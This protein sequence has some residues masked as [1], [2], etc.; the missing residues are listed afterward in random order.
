MLNIESESELYKVEQVAKRL[1]LVAPVA[2]RVNPN[3]DAKTYLFPSISTGLKKNR[4]FVLLLRMPYVFI[5][6]LQ[7]VSTY[8]LQV[9]TA[10]LALK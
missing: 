3:V 4:S 1:S 6:I 7:I 9:L 8:K 10:I 5:P 2:L